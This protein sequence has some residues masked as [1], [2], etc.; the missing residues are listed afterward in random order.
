MLKLLKTSFLSELR[1]YRFETSKYVRSSA[2]LYASDKRDLRFGT[3]QNALF[4]V[5]LKLY[6]TQNMYF[7]AVGSLFLN[8][9]P[10]I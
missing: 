6:I 10:L 7:V 9:H 1:R 8:T 5:T 4:S 2:V 3:E